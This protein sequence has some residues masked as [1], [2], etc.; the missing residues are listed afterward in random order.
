MKITGTHINYYFHCKRHLWFFS[1]QIFMEHTSELVLIG[2]FISETTYERQIHELHFEDETSHFVIDFFDKRNNIIHEV[3][4]TDK[5]DELHIWQVKFYIYQLKK[6]GIENVKGVID[7]PK[8]KKTYKVEL[9]VEDEIKLEQAFNDIQQIIQ[10]S[11]PPKVIRKP[12]CK[13]CSYYEL[14]YI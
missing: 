5:F 10:K 7:Y 9:S 2:K 8:L 1:H 11:K 4:K 13:K 3:K 12:F 14:C 6:F